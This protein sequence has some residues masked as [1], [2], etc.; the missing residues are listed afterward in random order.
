LLSR[1]RRLT[2]PAITCRPCG[3]EEVPHLFARIAHRGRRAV[4]SRH[5]LDIWYGERQK[6]PESAA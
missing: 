4:D 5:G 3:A 1:F 2:P 6:D